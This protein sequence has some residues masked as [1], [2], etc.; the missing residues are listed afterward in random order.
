MSEKD[1]FPKKEDAKVR[2]EFEGSAGNSGMKNPG[3]K[4]PTCCPGPV[5]MFGND[6]KAKKS[7]GSKK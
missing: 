2:Q 3:G 6:G 7:G 1:F 4:G 5:Q